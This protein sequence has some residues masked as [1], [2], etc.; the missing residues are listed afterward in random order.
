METAGD[1]LKRRPH[2]KRDKEAQQLL[3]HERLQRI[4]SIL[5]EITTRF[6]PEFFETVEQTPNTRNA[7][8][9]EEIE[10]IDELQSDLPFRI[11]QITRVQAPLATR[12]H[13]PCS[14]PTLLS[15]DSPDLRFVT[16]T[17]F[18]NP[19]TIDIPSPVKENSRLYEKERLLFSVEFSYAQTEDS[20]ATTWRYYFVQAI[21]DDE[22]G[23]GNDKYGFYIYQKSAVSDEF[24]EPEVVALN[25]RDQL[26]TRPVFELNYPSRNSSPLYEQKDLDENTYIELETNLQEVLRLFERNASEAI[27]ETIENGRGEA[28][29]LLQLTRQAVMKAT[30]GMHNGEVRQ[31]QNQSSEFSGT[32]ITWIPDI[33]RLQL[34]DIMTNL[35]TYTY[36]YIQ[37]SDRKVALLKRRIGSFGICIVENFDDPNG[38]LYKI[39][40]YNK[41]DFEWATFSERYRDSVVVEMRIRY[42]S[43]PSPHYECHI[44]NNKGETEIIDHRSRSDAINLRNTII[45]QLMPSFYNPR[46]CTN[47]FKPETRT[48]QEGLNIE[49]V[50]ENI[51]VL[52]SVY[53]IVRNP[54]TRQSLIELLADEVVKYSDFLE[55]DVD[56][57]EVLEEFNLP[58]TVLTLVEKS[59]T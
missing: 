59:I 40:L 4:N 35:H 15:P 1:I 28:I 47:L 45:E 58:D 3:S 44:V 6:A 22:E 17:Q 52:L 12:I 54:L 24:G 55:T 43:T 46:T 10:S 2:R 13:I 16:I 23:T 57:W 33:L 18:N 5:H 21:E 20:P 56:V 37:D 38:D 25:L 32:T 51:S 48:L 50:Q 8:I 49:Q 29:T 27:K 9:Q 30:F 36:P 31:M 42:I 11:L 19:I 7:T 53:D 41:E 34:A 26:G 39:F 14:V